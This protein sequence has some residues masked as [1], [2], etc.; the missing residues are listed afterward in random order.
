MEI[1]NFTDQN[2]LKVVSIINRNKPDFGTITLELSFHQKNLS[3]VKIISRLDM[4]VYEKE[5]KK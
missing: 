1:N 5:A 3:R 4:V 2:F